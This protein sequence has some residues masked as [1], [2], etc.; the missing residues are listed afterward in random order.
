MKAHD[1]AL[2]TAILALVIGAADPAYPSQDNPQPLP[3]ANLSGLHDFD[4]RVGHWRAHH[5]RLKERLAGSR[6][7]VEFDGTCVFQQLMGG[8]A[9]MDDNVFDM[10]GGAYR[11]V[12]LR[13]YDPKTAEWAIWWLDGRNPFGDLDPPVKGRFQNGVGTFYADDT[14]RGRKIRVRFIWSHISAISAHW[15]QAFSADGGR[16]WETNWITDFR[17]MP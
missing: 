14:L 17:R 1:L 5:R 2:D 4:L 10:P 3:E 9:N 12:T 16:T 11:G 15:E 8:R 7:W 13:A 6:E